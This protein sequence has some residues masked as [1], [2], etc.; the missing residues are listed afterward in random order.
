MFQVPKFDPVE[1]I[2]LADLPTRADALAFLLPAPRKPLFNNNRVEVTR[3][4]AADLAALFRALVRR[5]EDRARAQ[6]FV[7]QLLVALVSE[8]MQ[9]TLRK[10][11]LH[12]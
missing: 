3:E 7:L 9:V 2:A 8:D 1:K 11:C 12:Q 10:C 5:G 6:R 4:A